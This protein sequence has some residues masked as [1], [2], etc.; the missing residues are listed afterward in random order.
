MVDPNTDGVVGLPNAEGVVVVEPNA[1]APGAGVPKADIEF[2]PAGVPKA[3][4]EAGAPKTEVVAGAPNAL[5][6]PNAEEVFVAP[7]ADI[8]VA[9]RVERSGEVPV[10]EA[11]WQISKNCLWLAC[12]FWHEMRC[13]H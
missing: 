2:P 13:W 10:F 11:P 1:E 6:V 9:P 7:K 5:D 4:T 12:I 3:D 8:D